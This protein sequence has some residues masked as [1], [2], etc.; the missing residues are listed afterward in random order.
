MKTLKTQPP[1]IITIDA[2][3]FF[4]YYAKK[5]GREEN[6]YCFDMRNRHFYRQ[7]V[8]QIDDFDECPLLYQITESDTFKKS[9]RKDKTDISATDDWILDKLIIVDFSKIFV[10]VIDP[11]K[12]IGS[13]RE[14]LIEN[15]RDMI[16]NGF[17]IVFSKDHKVHMIPFDKSGNMS[18]TSRITFLNKDYQ[19]ELNSRLNLDMDFSSIQVI[20]SKYYA[21]RGLYLTSSRRV[22]NEGLEITPDTLVIVKDKREYDLVRKQEKREVLGR[23]YEINV[24]I[25]SG[26]KGIH[27]SSA[28]ELWVF[29]DPVTEEMEYVET[30]FD[31]QGLISPE[32]AQMINDS[33]GI[34]G[35]ASFQVRMPFVKGMLHQVDFREFLKD[36][37]QEEW[38]KS[39]SYEYEDAFGKIRDLKKAQ[40]LITESMF[41]CKKWLKSY[42][43]QN[44]IVDPMEYYCKKF[45]EYHH[46]LYIS[47]TDLP[48]GHSEYTHLS[49]QMINTLDLT[50]VEFDTIV[51]NH[52]SL[53]HNPKDY[54]TGWDAS[55]AY[56]Y[57]ESGISKKMPIWKRA[58]K[59]R[60][61]F[62]DDRYIAE[63]ISY[64]RKGLITKIANGKLVVAGQTRYLCRDLM[65]ML[66]CLIKSVKKAG[67]FFKRCLFMRFYMPME[68][69]L[70]ERYENLRCNG[71]CA[72]F[73]SPHLSR[74]EQCLLQ[75]FTA[76]SDMDNDFY[77]REDRFKTPHEKDH[78]KYVG[79]Y[80]KYFGHL[81]GVVMV[82]R[83]SIVPLC[84]GG[85]DF[86]G[87]LVNVIYDENVVE[88]V[89]R[90]CYEEWLQRKMPVIKIPSP[91]AQ[92]KTVPDKVPFEHINNTFSNAIGYLSNVAISIG[93]KEYGRDTAAKNND[94][95][96]PACWM[97]TYLTG[98]E[99]D[100]AKNGKHPDLDI[101]VRN[102]SEF[103]KANYLKFKDSYEEFRKLPGFRFDTMEINMEK[104]DH[105]GFQI[106]FKT[107]KEKPIECVIS[108]EE[109]GTMINKLPFLFVEEYTEYKNSTD[110]EK[111]KDLSTFFYPYNEAYKKSIS[112]FQRECR[113]VIK[114]FSEYKSIVD[115][116][117]KEKNKTHN[118]EK[119]LLKLIA[120]KY[121]MENEAGI[122]EDVV[123]GLISKMDQA[124]PFDMPVKE[125][126]DRLNKEKW[127]FQPLEK[128]GEVLEKI[129][130]NGF[131]SSC[132][133]ETEKEF[134]LHFGQYGFKTL[135]HLLAIVYDM[136]MKPYDEIKKQKEEK[137]ST[138]F[139]DLEEKLD[140]I[141]K[142]YYEGGLA[143]VEGRLYC[144]CLKEL[145]D[146]IE[147]SELPSSV[148]VSALYEKL[149]K[150]S[151]RLRFFWDAFSWKE[152]SAC[153]LKDKEA[154]TN[155]E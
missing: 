18:R 116:I 64:T 118:G 46:G 29:K 60:P 27:K 110:K 58:L 6:P 106:T 80:Q 150:N 9:I 61:E 133:D 41:K 130:G 90:G 151:S 30:P 145:K 20:L 126:L 142:A 117:R 52:V 14:R 21:Y 93:Q 75:P 34:T 70:K 37:D 105:K 33:I 26:E 148:K 115:V 98:L 100:A 11:E 56:D 155:A 121:D 79:Y 63:Q 48:Y 136:R 3:K 88:A 139:P 85:A 129:I 131:N 73:R 15:A 112:S 10:R 84:L 127:Q 132:L 8:K 51:K 72:F 66:A 57:E 91:D 47:G 62:E 134:L 120:K 39:D 19:E 96:A 119:Y 109:Y 140:R 125:V 114:L 67:E 68:K 2:D 38:E 71:Y 65:P 92:E 25:I 123:S 54:L 81:T 1:K 4:I 143:D 50:D 141:A 83:G 87:D 153:I 137:N 24:P 111:T 32:Y 53:I 16:E 95:D 13:K 122:N 82:P 12:P 108:P 45:T 44:G 107:G 144:V 113:D 99:I 49:Y 59:E 55:E 22:M 101:I 23:K 40:I 146:I 76:P 69:E 149:G 89:R 102:E 17:D 97:C 104:D 74:N 86:D 31:G 124:I 128:R 43:N 42:C 154:E 7:V 94:K 103:P 78:I 28:E 5:P 147:G 36:F 152:L 138:A 135:W 77:Y 35:A